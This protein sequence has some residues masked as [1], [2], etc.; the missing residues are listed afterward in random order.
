MGKRKVYKHR[1][2]GVKPGDVIWTIPIDAQNRIACIAVMDYEFGQFPMYAVVHQPLRTDGFLEEWG[3]GFDSW[4]LQGTED[5]GHNEGAESSIDHIVKHM[6]WYL[7]R[8]AR[9]A[10]EATR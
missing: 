5:R 6:P 9:K 7:R 3:W 2:K 10:V 8:R 4:L 1:R